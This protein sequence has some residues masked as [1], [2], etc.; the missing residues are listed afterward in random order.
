MCSRSWSQFEIGHC[1][2][3]NRENTSSGPYRVRQLFISVYLFVFIHVTWLIKYPPAQGCLFRRQQSYAYKGSLHEASHMGFNEGN[4]RPSAN[5]IWCWNYRNQLWWNRKIPISE[6]P[7]E[8]LNI[9]NMATIESTYL[10][11]GYIFQEMK[12]VY[13]ADSCTRIFIASLV[14]VVMI[15]N[16]TCLQQMNKRNVLCI[17]DE[18]LPSHKEGW[19]KPTT[20]GSEGCGE[21]RKREAIFPQGML[22]HHTK[23]NECVVIRATQVQ[24]ITHYRKYVTGHCC[25]HHFWPHHWPSKRNET[26]CK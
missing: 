16:H 15:W 11:P 22:V 1:D 21:G 10:I 17:H 2:V 14:T 9:Q 19:E 3:G 25:C 8:R 23:S 20:S 6:T 26:T 12:P 5:G 7:T 18:I 4:S 24:H 13:Q